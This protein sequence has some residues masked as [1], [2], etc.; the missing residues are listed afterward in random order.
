VPVATTFKPSRGRQNAGIAA[1]R[2][3]QAQPKEYFAVRSV[4][5]TPS[6]SALTNTQW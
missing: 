4:K 2:C 6:T 3:K 5:I 1:D